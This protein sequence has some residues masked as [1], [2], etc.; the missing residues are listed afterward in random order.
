MEKPN[1]SNRELKLL[2]HYFNSL[3][4]VSEIAVFLQRLESDVMHKMEEPLQLQTP[5]YKSQ[6]LLQGDDNG[7]S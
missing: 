3:C 1:W 4:G 5:S 6:A 7:Y 2:I